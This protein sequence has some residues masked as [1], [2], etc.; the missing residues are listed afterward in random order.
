VLRTGFAAISMSAR[1][2]AGQHSW[3]MFI[4]PHSCAICLQQSISGAVSISPGMRQASCGAAAQNT[5]TVKARARSGQ[6]MCTVYIEG[7]QSEYL[8]E[9]VTHVHKIVADNESQ[10]D[11]L[12]AGRPPH[13]G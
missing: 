10:I 2:T 11:L 12:A 6:D 1:G 8:I 4:P 5:A 9:V 13:V 7:G 3:D